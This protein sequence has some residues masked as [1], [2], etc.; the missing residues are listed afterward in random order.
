MSSS[1]G[2][3]SGPY[4]FCLGFFSIAGAGVWKVGDTQASRILP[5]HP[6]QVLRK[7]CWAG[8]CCVCR[9]LEVGPSFSL[10]PIPIPSFFF[11]FLGSGLCGLF[12]SDFQTGVR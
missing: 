7:T 4:T 12:P 5:T 1:G 2:S 11:F 10:P 9:T 3:G 8:H 6:T